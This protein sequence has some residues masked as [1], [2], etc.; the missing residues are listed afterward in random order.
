MNVLTASELY[1]LFSTTSLSPFYSA[2]VLDLDI[3]QLNSSYCTR[4]HTEHLLHEI[5]MRDWIKDDTIEQVPQYIVDSLT[6][7]ESICQKLE[8]EGINVAS[9][10]Y[11]AMLEM[12]RERI[13]G[14]SSCR[15]GLI[16]VNKR[17]NRLRAAS[18]KVGWSLGDP[19]KAIALELDCIAPNLIFQCL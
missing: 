18:K 3:R 16:D 10:K 9:G 7:L 17:N 15:K 1:Q 12:E 11:R 2:A 19:L 8:M 6:E 14:I 5:R 13:E 4:F